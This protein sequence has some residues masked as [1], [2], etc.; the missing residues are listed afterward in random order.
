MRSVCMSLDNR[1]YV[2]DYELPLPRPNMPIAFEPTSLDKSQPH[3]FIPQPVLSRDH[4][5]RNSMLRLVLRPL[6]QFLHDVQTN[7][8]RSGQISETPL[9][10][11]RSWLRQILLELIRSFLLG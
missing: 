7:C 2:N 11:L 1:N 8:V 10:T 4:S 9:M 3:E 5:R 6:M